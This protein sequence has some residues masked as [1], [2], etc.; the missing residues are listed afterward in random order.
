MPPTHRFRPSSPIHFLVIAVSPLVLAGCPVDECVRPNAQTVC[1][2]VC[3]NGQ[4]CD[5]CCSAH[6]NYDERNKDQCL[7]QCANRWPHYELH[8]FAVDDTPEQFATLPASP[9]TVG[10]NGCNC[11]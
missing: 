11:I 6:P 5:G 9:D 3:R 2:G 7:R 8:F 4:S 1:S 10:P